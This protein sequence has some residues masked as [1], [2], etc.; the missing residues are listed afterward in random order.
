MMSGTLFDSNILLDI[1]TKDAVWLDWSVMQLK[2]AAAKGRICVNP[3]IFAE[4]APAFGSAL[5]LDVWLEPAIF[6][7]LP[8]PYAAGWWA[9]QAFLQYRKAGGAKTSPLPDFYVGA[10]AQVEGLTLVTRD[11]ARYKTYFPI[12]EVVSPK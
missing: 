9:S 2:S 1:A 4:L 5:A 11:A 8:L 7:R 10:Y 6:T 12:L 3:V